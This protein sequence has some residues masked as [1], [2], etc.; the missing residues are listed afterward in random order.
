MKQQRQ[1]C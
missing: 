1:H